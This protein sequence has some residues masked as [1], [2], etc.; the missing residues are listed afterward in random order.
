LEHNLERFDEVVGLEALK[1]VHLN[2]SKGALGSRV[3]RHEHIGIGMIGEI[4]F[5]NILR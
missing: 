5:R 2:D 4:G 3:D 1:L